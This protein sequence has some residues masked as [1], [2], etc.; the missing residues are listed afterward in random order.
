MRYPTGYCLD[1]LKFKLWASSDKTISY[2]T[3]PEN[4]LWAEGRAG[5]GSPGYDG[6]DLKTQFK[7][8][9]N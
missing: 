4:F 6:N 7:Y 1:G 5:G 8:L 2:S 9:Y 3:R